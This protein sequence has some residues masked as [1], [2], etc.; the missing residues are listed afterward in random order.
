MNLYNIVLHYTFPRLDVEVTRCQNH[1]LK[2]PFCIHPK[3]GKLCVP[4]DPDNQNDF[5]LNKVPT[6]FT[7]EKEL[8]MI[9]SDKKY[10]KNMP[11]WKYVP[12][13]KREIEIFCRCFL[14]H[15]PRVAVSS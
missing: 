15:I 1:L 11:L 3:T 9:L 2:G 4:I 12:S 10:N 13:M 7:L 14:N 8:N 6:L 5:S